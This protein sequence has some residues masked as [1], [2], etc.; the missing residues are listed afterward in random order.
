MHVRGDCR[1]E[2]FLWPWQTCM[3]DLHEQLS[4]YGGS[5][6]MCGGRCKS[7]AVFGKCMRA[8]VVNLPAR[9]YMVGIRSWNNWIKEGTVPQLNP[10]V[11]PKF[12]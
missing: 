8:Q 7:Q 6:C 10:P 12:Y 9:T 3:K 2:P 5:Q 11:L 4:Q 1:Q